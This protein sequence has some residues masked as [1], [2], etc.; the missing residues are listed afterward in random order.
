MQKLP[1]NIHNES[2]TV[3]K[4]NRRKTNFERNFDI[5]ATKLTNLIRKVTALRDNAISNTVSTVFG[6]PL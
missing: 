2:E 3:F 1:L 6:S 4:P 5:S